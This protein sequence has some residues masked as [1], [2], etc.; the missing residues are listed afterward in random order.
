MTYY[1][2]ENSKVM[3]TSENEF[4]QLLEQTSALYHSEKEISG[5]FEALC[6]NVDETNLKAEIIHEAQENRRQCERLEGL[7]SILNH[8]P[9]K[10]CTTDTSWRNFVSQFSIA[11]KRVILKH[12]DIGY[13]AAIIAALALG[14]NE[15][16]N[17]LRCSANSAH[18]LMIK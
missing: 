1:R 15:I 9:H 13:K 5:I 4:R 10:K 14:Q 2:T 8:N 3:K 16:A 17:F 6:I 12:S 18:I 11:F 7:I